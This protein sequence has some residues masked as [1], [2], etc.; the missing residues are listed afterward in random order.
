MEPNNPVGTQPTQ[1]I[2]TK[3]TPWFLIILIIL[4]ASTTGIFAYKY[5]QLKQQLD[6]LSLI[7]EPTPTPDPTANWQT[8][9]SSNPGSSVSLCEDNIIVIGSNLP[10]GGITYVKNGEKTQCPV[11]AP[12]LISQACK[13]YSKLELNCSENLCI[14]N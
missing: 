5:F 2:P 6:Q 4:L 3:K 11:V 12:S 9:C 7:P 8:H 13:N 10:G 1:L 14:S